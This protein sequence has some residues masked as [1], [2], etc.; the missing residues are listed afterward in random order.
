MLGQAV[1]P[2]PALAG[3]YNPDAIVEMPKMELYAVRAHT[4]G[5]PGTVERQEAIFRIR[6][7]SL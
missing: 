7:F 6:I 1:A 2:I 4:K 5:A 3:V